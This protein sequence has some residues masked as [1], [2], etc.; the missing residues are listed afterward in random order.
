[1]KRARALL[2]CL[3]P[4]L[5]PISLVQV[6][7]DAVLALGRLVRRLHALEEEHAGGRQPRERKEPHHGRPE[8]AVGGQHAKERVV[9]EVL[10]DRANLFFVCCGLCV[11][12]CVG[13]LESRRN[14]RRNATER[15]T[16]HHQ[17]HTEAMATKEE[18]KR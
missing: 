6:A 17:D 1:M 12:V 10:E 9:V 3:I 7:V 2:P 14:N 11:C 5:S 15:A 8:R 18:N 16:Q 4:S 13:A